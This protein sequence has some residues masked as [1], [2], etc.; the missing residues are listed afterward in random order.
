MP[1][2]RVLGKLLPFFLIFAYLT[3]VSRPSPRF[4]PHFVTPSDARQRVELR[5]QK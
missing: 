2:Y 5:S 3:L 4:G 1:W